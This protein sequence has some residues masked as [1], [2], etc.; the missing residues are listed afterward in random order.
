MSVNEYIIVISKYSRPVILY[1]ALKAR[2][3]II[4]DVTI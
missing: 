3:E 4:P 2:C 1:G